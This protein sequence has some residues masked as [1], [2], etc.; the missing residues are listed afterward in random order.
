M[1][2][3]VGAAPGR[4]RRAGFG[5]LAAIGAGLAALACCGLLPVVGAGLLAVGVA[6]WWG[7]ALVGLA[8][9]AVTAVM[10]GRHLRRRARRGC[11]TRRRSQPGAGRGEVGQQPTVRLEEM[12]DMEE[13]GTATLRTRIAAR[14]GG[15]CRQPG[16]TERSEESTTS[17]SPAAAATATPGV[18]CGPACVT[19]GSCVCEPAADRWNELDGVRSR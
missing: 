12:M 17:A 4:P 18:G 13:T 9:V 10:L 7:G 5:A 1:S 19:A 16:A 6:W 2:R 14:G 11:S 15:G 3:A 8:A